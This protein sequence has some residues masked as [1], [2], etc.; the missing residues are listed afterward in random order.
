MIK[1]SP[2]KMSDIQSTVGELVS[3]LH[4]N[5]DHLNHIVQ[6]LSDES[7]NRKLEQL[8]IQRESAI[9]SLREKR[10]DALKQIL[11]QRAQE[12]EETS[13]KRA[14]ERQLIEERRIREWEEILARRKIEDEKWLEAID[15]EDQEIEKSRN[16]EDEEREREREEEERALFEKSENEIETL[17]NE[18]EK[19]LEEG[20]IALKKLDED[21][22]IINAQIEA[23]LSA[24]AVIPNLSFKSR[25]Q[26]SKDISHD[27]LQKP[28]NDSNCENP[29]ASL[30]ITSLENSEVGNSSFFTEVTE[31]EKSISDGKSSIRSSTSSITEPKELRLVSLV[32]KEMSEEANRKK[33][34]VFSQKSNNLKGS[35]SSVDLTKRLSIWRMKS[36]VVSKDLELSGVIPAQET[37]APEEHTKNSLSV[38]PIKYSDNKTNTR[39]ARSKSV[40]EKSRN[41]YL[42][43]HKKKIMNT[44]TESSAFVDQTSHD[45]SDDRRSFSNDKF[46]IFYAKDSCPE[47]NNHYCEISQ[48]ND[49][50][51]VHQKITAVNTEITAKKNNQTGGHDLG[52]TDLSEQE[53]L[54]QELQTTN[55]S[56]LNSPSENNFKSSKI[57]PIEY[58]AYPEE[59]VKEINSISSGLLSRNIVDSLELTTGILHKTES[60]SKPDF[61]QEHDYGLLEL[62]LAPE[63]I[64][65]KGASHPIADT[66]L[67]KEGKN[68]QLGSLSQ[69]ENRVLDGESNSFPESFSLHGL[70]TITPVK[71]ES[72]FSDDGDGSSSTDI[73]ISNSI[74]PDLFEFKVEKTEEIILESK[75]SY[76]SES[77]Q[78]SKQ[79]LSLNNAS[80]LKS[81]SEIER[82]LMNSISDMSPLTELNDEKFV[83]QTSSYISQ[84][85][86]EEIIDSDQEGTVNNEI[87]TCNT[88]K[89]IDP[90]EIRE[91]NCDKPQSYEILVN[92]P[93]AENF[94]EF[95]SI[96]KHP[97]SDSAEEHSIDI[98]EQIDSTQLMSPK[99]TDFLEEFNDMPAISSDDDFSID[100]IQ[101]IELCQIEINSN[102]LI[103]TLEKENKQAAPIDVQISVNSCITGSNALIPSSSAQNLNKLLSQKATDLIEEDEFTNRQEAELNSPQIHRQEKTSKFVMLPSNMRYKRS[104]SR[105]IAALKYMNAENRMLPNY[106]SNSQPSTALTTYTDVTTETNTIKCKK[107]ISEIYSDEYTNHCQVDLTIEENP[108]LEKLECIDELENCSAIDQEQDNRFTNGRVESQKEICNN[109]GKTSDVGDLSNHVFSAPMSPCDSPSHTYVSPKKHDQIS[110]TSPPLSV[111]ELESPQLGEETANKSNEY[112][113]TQGPDHGDL[114]SRRFSNCSDIISSSESGNSTD[115]TP[116]KSQLAYTYNEKDISSVGESK[117]LDLNNELESLDLEVKEVEKEYLSEQL[118]IID[119]I[120]DSLLPSEILL[121][122]PIVDLN[123]LTRRLS[124]DSSIGREKSKKF[125]TKLI[126]EERKYIDNKIEE[127]NVPL[128]RTLSESD[129]TKMTKKYQD[130]NLI[131]SHRILS[132]GPNDT[133]TKEEI[134]SNTMHESSSVLKRCISTSSSEE[135]LSPK[136]EISNTKS[137]ASSRQGL[138]IEDLKEDSNEIKKSSRII[139]S[140]DELC[141]SHL[142]TDSNTSHDPRYSLVDQA[143]NEYQHEFSIQPKNQPLQ[144]SEALTPTDVTESDQATSESTTSFFQKARALFDKQ[145]PSRVENHKP[146]AKTVRPLSGLFNLRGGMSS[147]KQRFDNNF[148][149]ISENQETNHNISTSSIENSVGINRSYTPVSYVESS[150]LLRS[151]TKQRYHRTEQSR[152]SFYE[153]LQRAASASTSP[154]HSPVF[155]KN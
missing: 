81:T 37:L 143:N 42:L 151:S 44:N 129:L 40:G 116:K 13:K 136:V 86:K 49:K 135:L 76:L 4:I 73:E 128:S 52:V 126:N 108:A 117:V 18:M 150:K 127:N 38:F 110:T 67:L 139:D 31:S 91:V 87:S 57:Y 106:L 56:I 93:N 25:R 11:A 71:S 9:H 50:S 12:K 6:S 141:N 101:E 28:N 89:C 123:K 154:I 83:S 69:L 111:S 1:T 124:Y 82:N 8:A 14:H 55:E 131:N 47:I 115:E 17:E 19:S 134:T 22:K 84:S 34:I 90:N 95:E 144:N 24:P 88:G 74:S 21:R 114:Y 36:E 107:Q 147:S 100:S 32:Q 46:E 43:N 16:Y 27:Q 26:K 122:S 146:V 145:Q 33:E 72:S 64:A 61:Q 96:E 155:L 92:Y 103:T 23:A 142:R 113:P 2:T 29:D 133:T 78:L 45:N 130:K 80:L 109:K 65:I 137:I 102:S 77:P 75:N 99:K 152:L 59:S 7:Y 112:I 118:S 68:K 35:L 120:E 63:S 121:Y 41:S 94:H 48:I 62:K 66:T 153:S 5:I 85:V 20:R 105:D 70:T 30:G 104:I 54:S 58:S 97:Y 60:S 148:L 125:G 149:A 140:E 10:A 3:K 119:S 39:I 53:I 79:N 132:N 98:S 51:N 138:Y 15:A